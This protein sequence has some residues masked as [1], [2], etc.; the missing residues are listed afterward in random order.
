MSSA[1]GALVT[2]AA[3]VEG[4]AT[5]WAEERQS[6]LGA[7]GMRGLAPRAEE[8]PRAAAGNTAWHYRKP[9]KVCGPKTHEFRPKPT[10]L[11]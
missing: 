10:N 3:C 11:Q 7:A 4:A 2:R 1:R 6:P 8:Q 9:V 5:R